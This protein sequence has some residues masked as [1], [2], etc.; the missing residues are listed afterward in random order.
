MII[1]KYL[2]LD[3]NQDKNHYIIKANIGDGILTHVTKVKTLYTELAVLHRR[4]PAEMRARDSC[5]EDRYFSL[6]YKGWC[7][8]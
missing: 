1:F 6:N 5:L 7:E 8:Y 4:T 3:S 2:Y